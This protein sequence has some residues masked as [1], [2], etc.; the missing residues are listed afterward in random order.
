MN[1]QNTLCSLSK[2]WIKSVLGF[3]VLPGNPLDVLVTNQLDA[4]FFHVYLFLFS[5]CFR[6]PGVHL[7][8][9]YCI[10]ATPGLCHSL[11]ATPL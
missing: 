9:N 3:T 4:Q 11:Y 1:I 2:S 7:Q 8:E 5:T 10:S 6:Q